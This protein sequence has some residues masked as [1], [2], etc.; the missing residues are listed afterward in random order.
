MKQNHISHARRLALAAF[1]G[2]FLLQLAGCGGGGTNL[3]DG[4]IVGTGDSGIAVQGQVTAIGNHS[5]VVNGQSF[6]TTGPTITVNGQPAADTALMVGMVVTILETV[7]AGGGMTVTSIDYHAEV[8]AVVTGVDATAQAFTA[9]GQVVQTNAQTLYVAGTFNT[10][11]NQVVEVSGFRSTPGMV[12]A[13][14]VIIKPNANPATAP[15]QVTGAVSS[16]DT[17]K[18]TFAIGLQAFDYSGMA[19]ATVPAGLA[20][21]VTARVD[22]TQTSPV[23]TVLANAVAIVPPT[24]PGVSQVEIEG[25][26]TEFSSLGSFKVNGQPTD[27]RSAAIEGGTPDMIVNGTLLDVE[28]NLVNG[29]LV[30]NK[31]EIEHPPVVSIDGI[32]QAVDANGG[33]VQI[34]GQI[35][36]ATTGTQF[37][38]SSVAALPSFSLFAVQVGDRL[39]IL[40]FQSQNGLIATRVERLNVDSPPPSQPPTSI[41][42]TISSFVS[43]GNFMVAGQLVNARSATYVGGAAVNLANGIVV[44]VSGTLTN[45]TLIASQVQFLGGNPGANNVTVSGSISSFVSVSNF[46]VAGQRIDASS[47]SFSNGNASNLANGRNVTVQGVTQGGTLV[48]QSVTFAQAPP[49]TSLQVQGTISNFVSVSSFTV[50]GQLVNAAQA[51]FSGGSASSLANGVSV[52]VQGTLQGNVLVATTV[53]IQGGG[54]PQQIEL[55]GLITNFVSISNFTVAGRVVDATNAKFDGGTAA[56]LANGVSVEVQGVLNGQVV[57]AS[58]VGFDD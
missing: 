49:A 7:H 20:N 51:T 37:I 14:L 12:L 18:R 33:A 9:L 39:S 25:L 48:A 32:V 8:Q 45:G 40:A 38:D 31:I 58:E 54:G 46:K 29:V 17:T 23:S 15:L 26:V 42:G 24:P 27:G 55:E 57:Q 36:R 13:T 1:A 56:N 4:G 43:K 3:A 47:A 50:S 16:L 41:Q 2:L 35:V 6:S 52:N 11:L 22:G 28:G 10:L 44:A 30:A 19:P 5:I 53:Q 34:G 21:G